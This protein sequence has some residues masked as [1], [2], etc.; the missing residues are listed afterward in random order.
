[1][2]QKANFWLM[3][4]LWGCIQ[5]LSGCNFENLPEESY[6]S[7][8]FISGDDKVVIGYIPTYVDMESTIDSTDL[9]IL[10]H[11]NIAFMNPDAS[12]TFLSGGEPVCSNAS[13]SDINYVVN[14]AHQENVKV[15]VSLGGGSVPGCSGDWETL[16]QSS[17][18]TT[19]V[20]N[21]SA[22]VQYF[23]LDGIDV[24]IE[25][26]LLSSISSAGNYTPFIQE[27]RN[28]LNPQGKLV[29]CATA[30][31]TGGRIPTSSIAYFDFIN[32]MSYDNGWGGT[33]NHSTYADAVSHMQTWLGLGCPAEK[34]V[35]GVPFYGYQ[36]TVGSGDVS[37]SDIIVLDP[38][39]A[40]MDEYQGY[41]YNGIP[42]IEAKTAYALQNGAGVMIW[43]LSQDTF[44]SLS[45]L[46]AIGRKLSE[47][48]PVGGGD[49]EILGYYTERSVT[50][51]VF[52][53]VNLNTSSMTANTAYPDAGTDGGS[54]V[55]EAKATT[56][57]S[58]TNYAT[59]FN[60]PGSPN[61]DLSSYSVFHLS[62]KSSSPD[63]TVIRLE[64]ANG[65]QINLD[66]TTYGFSYDGNWHAMSIPFTD[67]YT[68]NP[69]FDFTD[70]NDVVVV[71]SIPGMAASINPATYV[72]YVDDVYFSTGER[73]G[74]YTE[75]SVTDDVFS[76][77]NLNTSSMTANAA[78]PDAGTD[79][80]STVIEAKATTGGSATNY[81]TYFNYP[82]SP[83][84]DLSSYSVFHLSLKSSSPDET[85][86]RLEDANGQQINLD[87]TTY[88]FSYDGNWH[89]MSI[90]F[91]DM[92][93]QNPS[94][95]FTDV[96]DVVVVK[97]I[98]GMAASINPA[99]YVFYADDVYFSY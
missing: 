7:I 50:D 52:S 3:V 20:N 85:V 48:P 11:I 90:P 88:G 53:I 32:I 64:D 74:Y 5:L 75:R 68:Q 69:S 60:Y 14:K 71:K 62:L 2:K 79:G 6:E 86:I 1:M 73:L 93:T 87:P 12:G 23:N 33:G 55:I 39:A 67:M 94:F 22:L 24:D 92:S 44:D 19:V 97:S 89:A 70:V 21:L 59:Y 56:G 82:G 57:G 96:N 76:I 38:S 25:G 36:G 46:Q 95:D 78:Y 49:G 41:K 30:T 26:A 16:L 18:R 61:Q 98:P 45:L 91:T 43:E 72:F 80:G 84:Q 34:L 40:Y 27:L 63:E 37:Y 51:D 4:S 9:D 54:T 47:A 29:T 31:Y 83:N 35:L 81:A 65:Q 8:H 58:A 66:P 99:T 17:N 42:T 77:V 15:L 28:A 10:T 13:A